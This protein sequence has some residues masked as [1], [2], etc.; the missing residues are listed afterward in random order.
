MMAVPG[1][2]PLLRTGLREK[3][4]RPQLEPLSLGPHQHHSHSYLES[5][6]GLVDLYR[7]TGD[8]HALQFAEHVWTETLS[9]T[10]WASGG[11]PEVYGE[12]FEHNDETCSAVSWLFLNLS[13][14]DATGETRYADVAERILV[15]HLEFDQAASGGF[16][17]D[18]SLSRQFHVDPAN[19][20]TIADE[21][22]SM[23]GPRGL[24]E[25]VRHAVTYD[26]TGIDI[27]FY[28]PAKANVRVRNSPVHLELVT[29]YPGNGDVEVRVAPESTAVDME[30]RFRV[31]GWLVDPP[32][33][34]INGVAQRV[35]VREGRLAITRTWHRGD[36]VRFGMDLP[37]TIVREGENGFNRSHS[38]GA[39][40]AIFENASILYGPL[41]LMIDRARS[42][43]VPEGDFRVLLD[44]DATGVLRL[45]AAPAGPRSDA[46]AIPGAHFITLSASADPNPSSLSKNPIQ[47]YPLAEMT[48]RTRLEA[49]EY[50]TRFGIQVI[51]ERH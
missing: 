3:G 21:C 42:G 27:N 13:L 40:P 43:R 47:L 32:T 41:L 1:S 6:V 44:R 50:L 46:L 29:A 15:N 39:P 18:R 4:T 11:I 35:V 45:D 16:C 19:K 9:H 49:D 12:P 48:T 7:A 31:P 23:S 38:A 24:L 22:C 28:V 17:S 33:L 20:G 2:A 51:D 5:V 37:V 10:M 8:T 30:L 14:F 25:A 34:S 36:T 26:A